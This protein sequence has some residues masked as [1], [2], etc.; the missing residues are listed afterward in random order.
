MAA[1]LGQDFLCLRHLEAWC[2]THFMLEAGDAGDAAVNYWR[3]AERLRPRSPLLMGE[4]LGVR[5]LT[6]RRR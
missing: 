5:S 6:G 2:Y 4:G 1:G 3:T